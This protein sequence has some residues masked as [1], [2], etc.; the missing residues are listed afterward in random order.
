MKKKKTIYLLLPIILLVWGF[1]FFQ[2]FSYFFAEPSY[3]TKEKEFTVSIDEIKKDTFS[4]VANYR[5]PFLDK[6]TSL[7]THPPIAQRTAT[8]ASKHKA[9][10]PVPPKQWP[11]IK[12]KGMIKNNNNAERRVGIVTI[13]NQEFLVKE[14][15]ILNEISFIT[16]NKDYIKVSLQ[17]EQKTIIK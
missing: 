17:K 5:D 16:I 14:G 3:A 7:K 13:G 4:I 8:K 15:S 9:I 10:Q 2:L 11:V 6:K 1:V 12:Y